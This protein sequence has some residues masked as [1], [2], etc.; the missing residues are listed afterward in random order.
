MIDEQQTTVDI[1]GQ[2][3]LINDEYTYS[4][5]SF[6][7]HPVEG[8]LFNVRAVQATFDDE[9]YPEI[10][11]YDTRVGMTWNSMVDN[12]AHVFLS[13][14]LQPSSIE[15]STI[16][17]NTFVGG[18]TSG[19]VYVEDA[20]SSTA[21][22]N[23][24]IKNMYDGIG[25]RDSSAKVY[26]N[27]IQN[28][29]NI[30]ISMDGDSH[31]DIFNNTIQADTGIRLYVDG[32]SSGSPHIRNN[33]ITQGD[34]GIYVI[35]PGTA[36]PTI[37]YNDIN[38]QTNGIRIEYSN[39]HP[40]ITNNSIV[41]NNYGFLIQA[42]GNATIHG[43]NIYGNF[44]YGG[45]NADS[46]ILVDAEENWWGDSTGPTHP[47]NPGGQGDAVTYFIDFDPWLTVPAF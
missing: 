4:G 24:S 15:N 32:T 5:R 35:G 16:E 14:W 38:N 44:P 11:S 34:N 21:I 20:D 10:A 25:L 36:T 43:C 39:T 22:S 30:G 8:L 17:N 26:N 40:Q 19:A 27:Q 1:Q 2:K 18:S 12:L 29:Y 9:N 7:G 13:P 31:E 46:T 23:N 45:Y 6:E 28:I 41:D 3:F 37:E 42:G 47:S 33:T